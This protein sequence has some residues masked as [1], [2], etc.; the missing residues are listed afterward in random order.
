MI[1]KIVETILVLKW[2]NLR[3][4]VFRIGSK[5]PFKALLIVK[6]SSFRG[7]HQAFSLYFAFSNK[8][9]LVFVHSFIPS[10]SP[11]AFG[12]W[13]LISKRFLC[14]RVAVSVEE[15]RFHMSDQ[16]SVAVALIVL[17][18]KIH[19]VGSWPGCKCVADNR[20]LFLQHFLL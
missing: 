10:K 8:N 3:Y 1:A 19:Q 2:F 17:G 18:S 11:R 13:L 4:F 6:I 12:Y 9:S 14:S 15:I 16:W 20:S 5:T 7:F